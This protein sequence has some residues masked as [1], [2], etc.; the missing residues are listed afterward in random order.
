[1]SIIFI[2]TDNSLLIIKSVC[3][4]S[5]E[6]EKKL[7]QLIRAIRATI[8]VDCAFVVDCALCGY[9]HTYPGYY[10]VLY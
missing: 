10:I 8:V 9:V 6:R 4:Y 5:R 2:E 3:T 1:M 7:T